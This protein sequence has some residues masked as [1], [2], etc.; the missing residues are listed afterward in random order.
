MFK[1]TLLVAAL[2]A[3]LPAHAAK[4]KSIELMPL[5]TF[6]TGI[7]DDGAAEIVAYDAD[8]YRLFVIN[9]AE[10]SVDVLDISDPT[11]P[12]LADFI[13]VTEDFPEGVV[14]G[15]N[16]VAVR[17]GLVA[18]AVENEDKQANGWAAFYT[19]GGEFLG[20]VEAGALPDAITFT[21]NGNYA[22]VANEGE[23]S[24]DYLV[25]PEG[26]ITIID[27]RGGAPGVAAHAT[28]E[29]FNNA[30]LDP[31]IRITGPEATV[32]QDLEPEY[33]AT[34]HDSKTAWV[35]L[36]ENNAM[37]IVDIRSATVTDLVGLGRKD[38]SLP[39][40]GLDASD[41]DD[42]I[43]IA[44]W[45]VLGTHM[46]D[47]LDSFRVRG[48]TYLVTANEGDA[49]EY[50]FEVENKEACEA[51]GG[52]DYDEDDGCLS[53]IDEERIKDLD[54]DPA[55]FPNAGELQEN[56]AIG[57]LAAIT[58]EGDTDGDGDYDELH[59][60]GARSISIWDAKGKLVA[61]T[62][63]LMEV[64]T[65]E[66]TMFCDGD[67]EDCSGFNS[68]ND[69]N[70]SFDSRSDAKGPE[71][72]GVVVGKVR[73]VTYAFVG[74]ERVGGV[75]V[76]DVSKP[77]MPK[78]V[79]YVNNRDFDPTADVSDGKKFYGD[80]GPEGLVFIK[81]E[82]SPNGMPLLVVGAEVSG[83]TTIYQVTY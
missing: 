5:G 43:N 2:A 3:A 37:A 75:M 79:S 29:A 26:S 7:F 77:S 38:H 40:N 24:G 15:V 9:A 67:L 19:T 59:V 32:A 54:L 27:L 10:G 30:V 35:T 76:F 46:P 74:L 68:T 22:L 80:L 44:N 53:W 51:Q 49:R 71:P 55:A 34:S 70:D 17:E 65:A 8:G 25:D 16:S 66:A 52:L 39:G 60:F 1:R 31:S 48:R 18:V 36:Q 4:N 82:D 63:D 73:G 64:K 57:R 56:E 33:I 58:T 11:N 21:H 81:P 83:T 12:S 41:R 72:E 20:S 13:D 6:E 47:A 50:F 61:D 69:E 23:P 28:F 45:P 78:Y 14:G 62:G 42:A